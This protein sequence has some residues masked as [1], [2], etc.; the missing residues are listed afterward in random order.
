M[1]REQVIAVLQSHE[2]QLR[3]RG[4]LSAALFGSA[5]RGE[6]RPDSDLDILVEIDPGARIDLYEYVGIVQLI[7]SLFDVR[8][9]VANRATLQPHVR[10]SADRDAIYA[11]GA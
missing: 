5:A 3:H 2:G 6:A 8:V 4:V 9:D 7:E 10:P 11:F 1:T